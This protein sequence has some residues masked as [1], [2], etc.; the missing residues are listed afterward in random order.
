MG[1]PG[2]MRG[3][4]GVTLIELMIVVVVLAILGSISVSTYRRYML[5]SNR[6]DATAM[7]LRVQVAQ[8]KFFLQNNRYAD[9]DELTDAPPAGLGLGLGTGGVT[10]GGFYA[11]TVATPA[12][13]QY[14]ATAT[15]RE[16]QTED[17]TDCQTFT[18]NEQGVR[19]P[20]E[21]TGCWR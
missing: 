13:T 4:R 10:P 17:K 16:G 7:L 15:A 2:A 21:S 14:T 20:A 9:G 6:T 5:R 19:T 18:I 1:R 12:D 8:E 3:E 11:I